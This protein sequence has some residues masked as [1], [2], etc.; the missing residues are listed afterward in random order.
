MEKEL[1]ERFKEITIDK[2]GWYW[3]KNFVAKVSRDITGKLWTQWATGPS[4]ELFPDG[5]RCLS[6][7]EVEALQIEVKRLKALLKGIPCQCCDI[8]DFRASCTCV[9][10]GK[11][12]S[13]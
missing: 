4:Y 7:Q 3:S 13:E 6:P 11:K 2:P 9:E 1:Y 10:Y 12:V 5:P 8:G